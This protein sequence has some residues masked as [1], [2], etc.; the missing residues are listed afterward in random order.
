M[1][2]H[3]TVLY[4]AGSSRHL[5]SKA[6]RGE[7]AH[8]VDCHGHRFMPDYPDQDEEHWP[9]HI[10]FDRD[11]EPYPLRFDSALDSAVVVRSQV[12]F[13]RVSRSC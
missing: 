6:M 8:L 5:I 9:R 12:S 13:R 10:A 1:Q 2:T 3:P 11:S 4:V 7:G